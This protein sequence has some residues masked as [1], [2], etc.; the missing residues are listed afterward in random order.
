MQSNQDS[1]YVE[2]IIGNISYEAARPVAV[3]PFLPWHRPRKQFV[4]DKQ[5]REQI[6]QIIP[7]LFD[8]KRVIKYLGLPGTDLLDLRYFHDTIC[9]PNNAQLFYLGFNS[10]AT[11]TSPDSIELNISLDEVNKLPFVMPGSEVIADD[12]RN[13][14]CK[15][16]RAYQQT[17]RHG[18]YDVINLDLCDGFACQAPD[19]IESTHYDA[20]T[21]LLG[22]QARRKTPWLLLLTTRVGQQHINQEL[23][24][25]LIIKFDQNLA[26]C[27]AFKEV[28]SEHF[29]ISNKAE[30]DEAIKYG[31]GLGDVFLSGLCKWLLGIAIAQNPP[32][33]IELKSAL[34]YRVLHT[35]DHLDLVS[36]AIKFTPISQPA[37]DPLGLAKKDNSAFTECDIAPSFVKRLANRG[38][39]DSILS[40]DLQMM[41]S[42]TAAMSDLLKLARYDATEYQSWLE[43]GCQQQ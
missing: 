4:R 7:E 20:M 25:K 2:D 17:L 10:I 28:S 40:S 24:N 21:H 37:H 39:I 5:W 12:F 3:K 22:I 41:Q 15:N 33:K 1:E 9:E 30:L 42:M 29:Q 35:A 16:S 19:D 32:T 6:H 38:D 43:N 36:L 23:L 26:D 34:G 27:E 13:V 11:P 8:D 31:K 14:A 18:A